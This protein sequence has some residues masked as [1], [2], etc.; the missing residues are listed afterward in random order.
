MRSLWTLRHEKAFIDRLGEHNEE[1]YCKYNKKT[2]LIKYVSALP[3][4]S[5]WGDL[6]P[7]E[8]VDYAVDMLERVMGYIDQRTAGM[9]INVWAW[10]ETYKA[11]E[12]K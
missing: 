11:N 2:M 7:E 6:N 5:N 1:R 4:R 12:V 10:L 9:V 3:L 8:V